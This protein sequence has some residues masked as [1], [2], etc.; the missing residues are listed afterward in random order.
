MMYSI[1]RPC[2]LLMAVVGFVSV[3]T[4]PLKAVVI[5]SDDFESYALGS[6]LIGQGGWQAISG[7]KPVFIGKGGE[8]P[9][10]SYPNAGLPTKAISGENYFAGVEY[11]G[12]T[13]FNHPIPALDP[14][15]DYSF[16]I[17]TWNKGAA[18]GAANFGLTSGSDVD[19]L[20][21]RSDYFAATW[22]LEG[23]LLGGSGS[24]TTPVLAETR[25]HDGLLRVDI[26]ADMNTVEAFFDFNVGNGWTS[27]GTLPISDAAIAA[28]DG[29]GGRHDTSTGNLPFDV[30]NVL[31]T[32]PDVIP[33]PSTMLLIFGF[34]LT[35]LCR[36]VSGRDVKR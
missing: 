27:M 20:Y 5:F 25:S 3:A 34:A 15:K 26:D 12:I 4:Q 29:I 11:I 22:T 35:G 1:L 33:E 32:T 13:K 14:S 31:L 30:D 10:T 17:N 9:A 16:V 21:W 36:G 23:S 2:L 18:A 8:D 24:L 6:D 19:A 7:S 28:I